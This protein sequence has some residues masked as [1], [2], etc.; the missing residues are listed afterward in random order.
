MKCLNKFQFGSKLNLETDHRPLEF[1]LAA[2]KEHPKTVSARSTM[3]ATSLMVFEYEIKY[4]KGSS[5]PHGVAMSTLNLDPNDDEC[6]L[7]DY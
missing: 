7:V 1:I 2:N 4:E 3:Y 5:I 6:S